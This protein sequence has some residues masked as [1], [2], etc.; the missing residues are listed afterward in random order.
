M[1]GGIVKHYMV[2]WRV[3][4]VV[5]I[6]RQAGTLSAWCFLS[7]LSLLFFLE[8]T[9]LVQSLTAL[10]SLALPGLFLLGHPLYFIV[11]P[12]AHDSITFSWISALASGWPR[13]GLWCPY[14]SLFH[15]RQEHSKMRLDFL[16]F[17]SFQKRWYTL[18]WNVTPLLQTSTVCTCS[19][20][21]SLASLRT[22]VSHCV[23]DL[24]LFLY[25]IYCNSQYLLVDLQE[26]VHSG[27]LRF[28]FF[29]FFFPFGCLKLNIL[30]KLQEQLSHEMLSHLY[31]LSNDITK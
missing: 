19:Q 28:C 12:L 23:S 3:L 24:V 27:S 17:L 1:L 11:G 30:W 6:V 22:A 20:R 15:N 18:Y 31:L 16:L 14:G 26:T 13:A 21:P 29:F 2:S 4:C 25:G 9:D 10:D 7:L 5:C 8:Q